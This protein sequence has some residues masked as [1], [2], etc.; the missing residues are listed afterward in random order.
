MIAHYS[1]EQ[2]TGLTQTH[3]TSIMVGEKVFLIH[4]S[5]KSAV[6][7][8]I[9][10]AQVNGFEFSIASSFRDYHKQAT[11]WN[12]KFNGQRPIL[13]NNSQPLNTNL[14]NDLEK[15]VAIM[16]WSALPGASR[17]HWGCELDV[18]AR[19]CLPK[20]VP[21]KLE[22]WEYQTGHQAEFSQWLS[23]A[24]ATFDFYLPYQKD[25]GGVAIEP[26]HIS[27]QQTSSDMSAQITVDKLAM[28]WKQYPFLG[29]ETALSNIE[30]LYNRFIINIT[31]PSA[32]PSK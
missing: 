27:H 8:L 32:L 5:V 9:Q 12:T 2:L 30:M 18:Y 28:I 11:I 4:K 16:R 19:N 25:L 21:L 17:H 26:W 20:G 13:D 10:D 15:I 24:L 3:L 23:E 29:V 6:E 7:G 1:L 14:L 22:P 31:L